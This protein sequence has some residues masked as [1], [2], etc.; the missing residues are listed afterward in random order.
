[1]QVFFTDCSQ[2]DNVRGALK[3]IN[4]N[5]NFIKMAPAVMV[6]LE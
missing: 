3:A 4:K 6:A 2:A 1:M 5:E